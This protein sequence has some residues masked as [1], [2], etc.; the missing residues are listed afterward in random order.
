MEAIISSIKL[1]KPIF[2]KGFLV[3]YNVNKDKLIEYLRDTNNSEKHYYSKGV[4]VKNLDEYEFV[5]NIK[6]ELNTDNNL[7]YK[8][9]TRYWIHPKNN[10]TQSHY[11]GD[12]TNVINICIKG[13]K[14]FIL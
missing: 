10:Y 4:F 1:N 12:G 11:D 13:K 3:N 7:I 2:L 14:K 6:N 9:K 5:K 8:D